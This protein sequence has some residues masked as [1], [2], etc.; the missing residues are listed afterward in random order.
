MSYAR[1][2]SLKT[3]AYRILV[4][5]LAMMTVAIALLLAVAVYMM[6]QTR[7]EQAFVA[8]TRKDLLQLVARTQM[9]QSERKGNFASA[10]H[11]AL[12]ESAAVRQKDELG[13]VVY[14]RFYLPGIPGAEE[15]TDSSLGYHEAVRNHMRALPRPE[16]GAKQQVSETMKIDGHLLL[17]AVLPITNIKQDVSLY[18]QVV[19]APSE[20][21]IKS[22]N[23]S[24]L[25]AAL[26]VIAVVF[27]TTI[28]LYPVIV[29]LVNRLTAFS[30]NL[31][32]ANLETLSLLGCVIAKRDSSTDEHNYRVTLY[33]VRIAEKLGMDAGEMRSL[34]KGA[35]LHDIGKIAIQDN[36]LRKKDQL[37]A[38]EFEIMKTHVNHGLDV[39][40]RSTWLRDAE[41]VVGGHHEKYD[42]KGYPQGTSGKDIPLLARIFAVADVFDALTSVRPYKEPMG[43]EAA[44]EIL[45][46][47]RNTHFDPEI[48]DVFMGQAKSLY[49]RYANRLS[50]ELRSELLDVA[51]QYFHDGADGLTY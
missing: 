31:I 12:E 34:V 48:L 49:Q 44:L 15:Y 13:D 28:L 21:V 37:T 26:G 11:Q 2:I 8:E 45:H 3:F 4:A 29:R 20:P 5:R 39:V 32:T 30:Q 23:K 35:F 51:G 46:H 47:R 1:K 19:Y 22:M 40:T 25:R 27:M 6:E 7:L 16:P 50:D 18:T 43:C 10:F 33:A 42:G 38:E 36:I 9:I 17:H 14:I 41:A 24:V